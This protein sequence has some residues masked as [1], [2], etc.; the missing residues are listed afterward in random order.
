MRDGKSRPLAGVHFP[1]ATR[2]N[3]GSASLRPL[4]VNDNDSNADSRNPIL[5][6]VAWHFPDLPRVLA[7]SPI[8]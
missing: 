4:D 8:G 3:S 2:S 7:D 5:V 6:R 1:R